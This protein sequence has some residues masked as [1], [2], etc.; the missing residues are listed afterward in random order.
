MIFAAIA[1]TV[2]FPAIVDLY[3]MV[4]TL[5]P[6]IVTRSSSR[7]RDPDRISGL[8]PTRIILSEFP[9]TARRISV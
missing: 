8:N 1:G 3:E 9:S 6:E 4:P 5:S 7:T 2:I